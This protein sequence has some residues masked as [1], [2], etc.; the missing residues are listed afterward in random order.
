MLN[1]SNASNSL[2]RHRVEVQ[3][4]NLSIDDDDEFD[5]SEAE[6]DSEVE[7]DADHSNTGQ[8]EHMGEEDEEDEEDEEGEDGEDGVMVE[9]VDEE[10]VSLLPV[11]N[12]AAGSSDASNDANVANLELYPVHAMTTKRAWLQ[13]GD[14][15]DAANKV[16]IPGYGHKRVLTKQAAVSQDVDKNLYRHRRQMLVGSANLKPSKPSTSPDTWTTA[17]ELNIECADANDARLACNDAWKVDPVEDDD[18]FRLQRAQIVSKMDN[19]SGASHAEQQRAAAARQARRAGGD[20]EED[21]DDELEE[22][23]V[24]MQVEGASHPHM[25]Q[26][27]NVIE[28]EQV[29]CVNIPMWKMSRDATTLD[30]PRT[31]VS[32]LLG[33]ADQRSAAAAAIKRAY[34]LLG[35]LECQTDGVNKLGSDMT[36]VEGQEEEDENGTID[37][38]VSNG[39]ESR[40]SGPQKKKAKKE[41]AG[42]RQYFWR[43]PQHPDRVI[44][45]RERCVEFVR[46]YPQEHKKA[47]LHAQPPTEDE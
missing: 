12:G 34:T 19:D 15:Y 17:H 44:Q 4:H 30:E 20:Y 35:L 5:D 11:G 7:I 8:G 9:D 41:K 37:M 36:K 10:D 13:S 6:N 27:C 3:A 24:D 2:K 14:T 39:E 18:R 47:D 1:A 23:V 43:N 22:E 45:M 31:D 26:T 40:S 33:S 42:P 46:G 25:S 21:S 29:F 32:E 16:Q 28:C 38:S